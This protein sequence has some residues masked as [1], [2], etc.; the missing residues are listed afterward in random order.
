MRIIHEYR[1]G[2]RD[3]YNQFCLEHPELNVTFEQFRKFLYAF[4]ANLV[5]HLLETGDFVKLP[6]GLGTVVITKYKPS[7]TLQ[8]GDKVYNNLPVDWK[9]TK[10]NGE[11]TRT[12]NMHTDGYA[13]YFAWLPYTSKIKCKFIWSFKMGRDHSRKLARLLKLPRS[14]YKDLYKI[15]VKKP[16]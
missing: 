10:E 4:N 1:T 8:F 9:L 7:K 13:Y 2:S 6:F 15:V 3:S 12:L 5:D 14:K 16:Q 11:L